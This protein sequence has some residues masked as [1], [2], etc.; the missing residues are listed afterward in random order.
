MEAASAV[1]D[2]SG[3]LQKRETSTMPDM[4]SGARLCPSLCARCFWSFVLVFRLHRA[5]PASPTKRKASLSIGLPLLFPLKPL[6]LVGSAHK[7][8]AANQRT[9]AA[10]SQ[11][12]G[13]AL[14]FA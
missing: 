9:R 12:I 7:E 13:T 11:P 8:R 3:S 1:M 4:F 5:R 14:S 2:H 6:H 10:E